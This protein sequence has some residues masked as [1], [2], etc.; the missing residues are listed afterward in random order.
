MS[1]TDLVGNFEVNVDI[2]TNHV[3]VRNITQDGTRIESM[4]DRYPSLLN[5]VEALED[6]IGVNYT[7]RIVKSLLR[8]YAVPA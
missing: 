2:D 7:D 4:N 5:M 8:S 6:R 1:H 3:V